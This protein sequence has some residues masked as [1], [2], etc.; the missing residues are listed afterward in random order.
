MAGTHHVMS[1]RLAWVIGVLTVAFVALA[2]GLETVTRLSA[3]PGPRR[4]RF[5]AGP[6]F[7]GAADIET[8]RIMSSGCS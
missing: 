5:G 8:Y 4:P 6:G 2:F 3:E 7:P 1:R